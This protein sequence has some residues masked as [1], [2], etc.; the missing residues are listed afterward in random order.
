MKNKILGISI[1]TFLIIMLVILTGCGNS[2]NNDST[3]NSNNGDVEVTEVGNLSLELQ[4]I[5]NFSEGLASAKKDGKWGYIDK[6]GNVVIDFIYEKAND[7]SEGLASVGKDGKAGYINAKGE[8]VV[9]FVYRSTYTFT[10]GYGVIR[11][12][13]Y[14]GVIDKVGNVIIEPNKYMANIVPLS[15]DLFYVDGGYTGETNLGYDI[16]DKESKVIIDGIAGA[17]NFSEGLIAVKQLYINGKSDMQNGKWGFID[18]DG[19]MVIDYQYDDANDF[20]DGLVRVV[21]DNKYGFIDKNNNII[22]EIN[23]EYETYF[24]GMDFSEG[25]ALTDEDGKDIYIDTTGKKVFELE[26]GV[27]SYG[28]NEGLAKVEKNDMIGYI[29]KNGKLV[30]N[31]KYNSGSDFSDGLAKVYKDDDCTN[32][33]F[34]NSEGKTILAGKIVK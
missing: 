8:V 7:F 29:N 18:K 4:Q 5:N 17:R 15:N 3:D 2:T 9:D 16:I 19:N 27:C 10:N 20:S 30:V 23:R 34:I 14:Y 11:D 26:D 6:K 28:F 1:I 13:S 31:Y 21:K 12:G 32:F 22:I 24:T 33:E 25:L